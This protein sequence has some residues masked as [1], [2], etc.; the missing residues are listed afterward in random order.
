MVAAEVI[1]LIPL[2][3][4]NLAAAKGVVLRHVVDRHRVGKKIERLKVRRSIA[5]LGVIPPPNLPTEFLG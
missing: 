4:G 3:H 1:Y 5:V 2:P